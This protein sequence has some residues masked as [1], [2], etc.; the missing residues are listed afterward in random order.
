MEY[1]NDL[2]FAKKMD[3]EDALNSFREKFH[4]PHK[5]DGQPYIYLCGN[6]LGLQP[7]STQQA[8][9]QELQDWKTYGVEGHFHAKNPWLPYHEFLS[10]AMAK[11]V[12][13]SPEEVVVMNTLTVNLH[14]MMVSFYR[15]SGKRRKILIEADA[16]PSDKYGAASQIKFHGLDPADCLIELAAIFATS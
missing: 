1:R 15:P 12:G 16:F 4:L 6:S 3:E 11:V 2:A 5:K 10:E 14:L 9:E 8:L 7:K 13:A